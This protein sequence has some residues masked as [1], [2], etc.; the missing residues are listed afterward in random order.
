MDK[1]KQRVH[2]LLRKTEKHTKTDMVYVVSSAAWLTIA[3]GIGAAAG[4]ISTL[5]LAAVL[6]KEDFGT[7][8][9]ALS[10]FGI[11]TAFSLTGINTAVAQSVARSFEGMVRAGYALAMRWSIP[12]VLIA[13]GMSGYYFV[14]E[15]TLLALALLVIAITA[16]FIQNGSIYDAFFQG[17]KD[18][19][20]QA[21]LSSINV[22][23]PVFAALLA[24]IVFKDALGVIVTYFV[25]SALAAFLSYRFTLY[26]YKPNDKLDPESISYSKHLS[27]M[28]ILGA[29]S[30]QADRV[31]IFHQLGAVA[32]AGYALAL[33]APQQLRFG[34][35][36][37]AALSLPKF[38]EG[39]PVL[40][41][42]SL[43]RKAFIV[44][45][46]SLLIALGYIVVAPFFFALFFP[47][48]IDVVP[49]SQMFALVILFFPSTLYQQYLTARME[50]K[51]LYLL[52]TLV[53]GI[54]LVLLVVLIPFYG[55]WGALFSILGMEVFRLALLLYL[56]KRM[57]AQ[58]ANESKNGAA[59]GEMG[60][61]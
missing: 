12:M 38:A 52:Q 46:V 23:I 32:L 22:A 53:P 10:L 36:I 30:V 43:P 5:V 35:K 50:K 33:A 39:D 16:P 24:A 29:I 41:R 15:N 1:L 44:F 61:E 27:V 59:S 19:R 57:D 26:A 34:S 42:A 7:Y 2:G 28:G 48:Y 51:K 54:K 56:F 17:K 18:F 49:Y 21:I 13:L 4:F 14:Q 11:I 45:C 25:S 31:L 9:F 3:R 8:K 37:L 55:I 40:I 6:A 20:M 58:L 60:E 47:Q